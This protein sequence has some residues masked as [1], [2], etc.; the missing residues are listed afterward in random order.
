MAIGKAFSMSVSGLRELDASLA[1]LGKAAARGVM[2]RTLTR[3]A[4]PVAVAARGHAAGNRDTGELMDA[5]AVG[6]KVTNEVGKAEFSKVLKGGGS[7]QDA[8]TAMRDA[9]RGANGEG[10]VAV[11]FIGYRPPAGSAKE[12]KARNIKRYA[13]EFGNRRMAPQ[14]NLRPAWDEKQGVVLSGIKSILG[15]EIKKSVA[16]KAKTAARK[17]AK[18]AAGA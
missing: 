13:N 6:T 9:R 5:I 8:V 4:E 2:T 1:D 12:K 11:A 7:K 16:R 14:P 3:A 18:A 15:E 10:T 17:A